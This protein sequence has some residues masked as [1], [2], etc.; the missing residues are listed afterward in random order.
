MWKPCIILLSIVSVFIVGCSSSEAPSSTSIEETIEASVDATVEAATGQASDDLAGA[1]T[2]KV[3]LRVED[4]EYTLSHLTRRMRLELDTGF[5]FSLGTPSI[6]NLPD[7]VMSQLEGEALLLQ[8]IG[9]LDIEITDQDIGVEV[10]LR[11]DLSEETTDAVIEAE[12][13]RQATASGLELGEYELMLGAF[14]AEQRAHDHFLQVGPLAEPQVRGRMLIVDDEEEAESALARRDAG[15]DFIVVAREVT[16]APSAVEIE[17]FVRDGE[18]TVFE[19]VQDFFFDAD[20]GERSAVISQ[21]DFFYIVEVLE[22]DDAR[23]LDDDQREAVADRQL[24][25][26]ISELRDSLKIE[27][28]LSQDDGIRALNEIS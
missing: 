22:K 27:R 4:L 13:L 24:A 9:D 1:L 8:G 19:N 21:R 23:T 17:W 7:F 14:L 20:I 11:G 25:E 16:L 6:L 18:P 2:A 3:V 12:L 15:E 5:N 10:A 26:W 28:I